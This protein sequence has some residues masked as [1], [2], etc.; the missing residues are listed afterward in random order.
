MCISS[1]ETWNHVYSNLLI[2]ESCLFQI[3]KFRIMFILNYGIYNHV[4]RRQ[5]NATSKK[6][7][8]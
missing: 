8:Y 3:M 2:S 4:Y 1:Y 6:V 5:I 7:D